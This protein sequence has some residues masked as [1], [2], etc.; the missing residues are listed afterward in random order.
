MT[1]LVPK[2]ISSLAIEAALVSTRLAEANDHEAAEL[3]KELLS[4]RVEVFL[5]LAK[6]MLMDGKDETCKEL[7]SKWKDLVILQIS[8]GEEV[9]L[10]EYAKY[11]HM[12]V[13]EL[14]LDSLESKSCATIQAC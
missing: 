6:I 11:D 14:G 12:F 10:D 1:N 5:G 4:L 9:D 2:N 8:I 13:R 7:Y 3:T